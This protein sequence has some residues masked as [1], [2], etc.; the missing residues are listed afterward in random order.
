M[1]PPGQP[2]PGCMPAGLSQGSKQG[3]GSGHMIRVVATLI[4]MTTT[5][6]MIDGDYLDLDTRDPH[7]VWMFGCCVSLWVR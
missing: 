7:Q 4:L 2:V 1:G 5:V 3:A 6:M